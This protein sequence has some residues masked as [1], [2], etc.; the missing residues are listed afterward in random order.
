MKKT[1]NQQNLSQT[2]YDQKSILQRIKEIITLPFFIVVVAVFSTIIMNLISVP[3]LRLV[4]TDKELYTRCVSWALIILAA[5]YI[6]TRITSSLVF[7][8]KTGLHPLVILR[9]I[10]LNRLSSL[11]LFIFSLLVISALAACLIFLFN[12]NSMFIENIFS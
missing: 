3:I 12:Y 9:T 8:V 7:Y 2:I 11:F 10:V 4:M 1:T 6:L 5:I